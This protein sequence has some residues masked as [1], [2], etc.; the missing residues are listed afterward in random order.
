M[1]KGEDPR[2]EARVT[3]FVLRPPGKEDLP[4]DFYAF[5]SLVRS[6]VAS[7]SSHLYRPS[8]L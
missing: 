3:P 7:S 2:R 6:F 5:C 8:P 4:F 1:A